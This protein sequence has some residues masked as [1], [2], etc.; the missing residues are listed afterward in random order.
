MTSKDSRVLD[1]TP[2]EERWQTGETQW[3]AGK[4]SPA[5]VDLLSSQETRAM[6]PQ[7]GQALVPGCGSASPERKVTG[8]DISPT[9][10]Q[11]V[12]Q[13]HPSSDHYQ[14]LCD[15]FFKF[16]NQGYR[17]AYDY[18]FLCALPPVLRS[19]WAL[20]YAELIEKGGVLITL[21]YPLEEKEGGP[22]F[23]LSEDM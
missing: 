15:D 18:T 2:W 19:D 20:R 6:I 3:D 1:T 5:L 14:F 22:P 9:C 13:R 11:Q 16:P 23:S 17:L 8:L 4:P 7:D 21:M 12:V 10:I